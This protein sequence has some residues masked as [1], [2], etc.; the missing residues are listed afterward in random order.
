MI[1]KEEDTTYDKIAEAVSNNPV[2][3]GRK[4]R[5]EVITEI[6]RL[7]EAIYWA[8]PNDIP[9]EFFKAAVEGIATPWGRG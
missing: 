4:S 5:K 6:Q 3:W 2:I 9:D 7:V 1:N 8:L